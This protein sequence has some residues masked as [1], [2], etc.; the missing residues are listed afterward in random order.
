[1][2]GKYVPESLRKVWEWLT[3]ADYD[4]A[5]E[6]GVLDVISRYSRRNVSAQTG[7]LLDKTGLDEL[8]VAGDDA[9]RALKDMVP[10]K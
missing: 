4:A 5:K 10:A 9:A 2:I 1:M 3:F 8:S 7:W 6:R